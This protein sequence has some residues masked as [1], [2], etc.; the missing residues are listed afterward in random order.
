MSLHPE[1]YPHVQAVVGALEGAGLAVGNHRWEGDIYAPH[2]VVYL[3]AGGEVDGTAA[4]PNSDAELVVQLTYVGEGPEQALR[5]GD[6]ARA[7]LVGQ[8]LTVDGRAPQACLLLTGSGGA[9]PDRD[10]TPP[11]FYAYDRISFWSFPA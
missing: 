4:D 9:L 1:L 8:R 5:T 2:V 10:V 11:A 3:I 6:L 7:A